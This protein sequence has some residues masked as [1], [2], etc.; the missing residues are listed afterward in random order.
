MAAPSLNTGE[1]LPISK[2]KQTYEG[3]G[4]SKP[5]MGVGLRDDRTYGYYLRNMHV[6]Y[7]SDGHLCPFRPLR[8]SSESCHVRRREPRWWG[9]EVRGCGTLRCAHESPGAILA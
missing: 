2:N 5:S 1:A 4:Y 9:H 7:R 3:W 8:P 6:R